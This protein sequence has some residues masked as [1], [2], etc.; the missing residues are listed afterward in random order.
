MLN[1]L[2]ANL[3]RSDLF[4]SFFCAILTK[5]DNFFR[6]NYTN[7]TKCSQKINIFFVKFLQFGTICNIL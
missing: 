1:N 3:E 4:A 7:Y 2:K 5:D 6:A